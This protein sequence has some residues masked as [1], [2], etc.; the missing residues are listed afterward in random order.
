MH[1]ENFLKTIRENENQQKVVQKVS[2]WN[3][4]PVTKN[5]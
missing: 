2:S 5:G 3:M 1:D 4:I